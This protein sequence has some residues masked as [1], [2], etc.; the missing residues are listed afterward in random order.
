MV[1]A[2]VVE[3]ELGAGAEIDAFFW[4]VDIELDLIPEAGLC[5]E[6]RFQIEGLG[7]IALLFNRAAWSLAWSLSPVTLLAN[8]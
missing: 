1:L 3:A 5:R 2:E 6:G 4:F 7:E 8:S